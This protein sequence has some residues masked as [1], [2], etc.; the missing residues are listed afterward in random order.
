MVQV[1]RLQPQGRHCPAG[2]I[3][4]SKQHSWQ[5][6]KSDGIYFHH[7][8]SIS[9]IHTVVQWHIQTYDWDSVTLKP[10]HP[11]PVHFCWLLF[12]VGTQKFPL[13]VEKSTLQ[14]Q[15]VNSSTDNVHGASV[16]T[17]SRSV[18]LLTCPNVAVLIHTRNSV[19]AVQAQCLSQGTSHSEE[20]LIAPQITSNTSRLAWNMSPGRFSLCYAIHCRAG[21]VCNES[22]VML[23]R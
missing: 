6:E 13:P 8:T 20:Q 4:Y 15:W 12:S 19:P 9:G 7:M 3:T 16:V 17:K 5:V 22:L 23:R 18:R 10:E 21:D 1:L 2:P 14:A 11:V